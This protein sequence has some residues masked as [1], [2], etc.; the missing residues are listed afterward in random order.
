MGSS[1]ANTPQLIQNVSARARR[2]TRDA[3]TCKQKLYIIIG[4]NTGRNKNCS[5]FENDV[6]EKKNHPKISDT[7]DDDDDC[8]Y[9]NKYI[10]KQLNKPKTVETQY[11][12][13]KKGVYD[14]KIKKNSSS[15]NECN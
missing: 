11:T 7:S 1:K 15:K 10:S 9:S 6:F 14:N 12:I 4:L 3:S 13:R 8:F 2:I 5:N